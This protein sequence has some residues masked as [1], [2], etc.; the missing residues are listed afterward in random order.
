M[1]KDTEADKLKENTPLEVRKET[2]EV[3][4]EE[5]KKKVKQL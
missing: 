3:E 2:L 4:V 5:K 1:K